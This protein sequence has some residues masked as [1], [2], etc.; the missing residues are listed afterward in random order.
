MMKFVTYILLLLPCISLGQLFPKVADLKGNIENIVEKR[1]GREVSFL[2]FMKP[3]YRAAAYSGWKYTFQFDE[4]SN[5]KKRTNTFRDELK[6]D[7][8]YQTDTIDNRIIEK[9]IIADNITGHKEDY[10]EHEIFLDSKGR[11][12]QVNFWFFNRTEGKRELFQIDKNAKYKD[13]KLMSFTRHQISLKGDT[14]SN[15]I[16]NLIYDS[17][18]KLIRTER[19]DLASGFRTII[20]YSYNN[21][22]LVSSYSLDFLMELQ[23]YGKKDQISE[24]SYKYDKYGNWI[25]M[26][27]KSGDENEMEARRTIKYR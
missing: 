1:Y 17:S 10:T 25:R 19:K 9:E 26:Y 20:Q 14:T 5:L 15:E 21:E 7:Y 12:E 11:V 27:W 6:A 24:I 3:K 18:G 23:E 4:K 2:F 13:D 16:C 22:R 8:I